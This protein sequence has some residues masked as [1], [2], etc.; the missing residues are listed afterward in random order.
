MCGHE[1]LIHL[2]VSPPWEV[3]PKA[4]TSLICRPLAPPHNLVGACLVPLVLA[5]LWA[6]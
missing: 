2:L 6:L 1:A 4:G 3:V 5:W